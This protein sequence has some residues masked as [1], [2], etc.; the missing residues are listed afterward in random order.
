[1]CGTAV[2]SDSKI[3]LLDSRTGTAGA[4]ASF[5]PNR[6]SDLPNSR[7]GMA[8]S[9]AGQQEWERLLRQQETGVGNQSSLTAGEVSGEQ[10]WIAV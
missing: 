4:G 5:R 8:A 1:M 3:G 2:L 7:S 10:D 9:G 6:R